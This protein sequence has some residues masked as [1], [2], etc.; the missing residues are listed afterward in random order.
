MS[1]RAGLNQTIRTKE[2][3]TE[4]SDMLIA[5]KPLKA[6]ARHV[7]FADIFGG[8]VNALKSALRQ[9]VISQQLLRNIRDLLIVMGFG[10]AFYLV[11]LQSAVAVTEFLILAVVIGEVITAITGVQQQ[12]QRAGADESAYYSVHKLIEET[13]SEA[14]PPSIG[15][16]PAFRNQ[17]ALENVYFAYEKEPIL[18]GVSIEVDVGKLTVITGNSGAGKTT[19][20]DLL[21]GLI[22]P[23]KGRVLIDG[24]SLADINVEEWR[25]L[26][27]YVP[28]EVILLHDT[29]RNNITM[30]DP[31]FS[32]DDV[33]D[34]LVTAGIWEFA[35]N[36]V[37]G[38]DTIVGERG[39]KISGG[40]RQRIALARA[41]VHQPKFLILDEATSALDP[42]TEL[43]ICQNVRSLVAKRKGELT[44]LA[45]T[46]GR[47]WLDIADKVYHLAD[48]GLV[49]EAA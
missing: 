38:L 24:V 27:G 5:I 21:I 12:M 29:I 8:Q 1:R 40:Q 32:D 10:I 36:S 43:G 7:R 44:V 15:H 16:T 18:T 37:E 42:E 6:M 2:L 23:E 20:T 39:T 31:G 14:E 33:R 4:L 41:L 49:Q 17:C 30:G 19:S 13:E 22:R 45:I 34:A 25:R 46:H 48:E 26:V 3:V 35:N 28:Q 47:A 9:Q 11:V